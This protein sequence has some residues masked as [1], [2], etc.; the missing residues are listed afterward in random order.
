MGC[1]NR[2]Y[3]SVVFVVVLCLNWELHEQVCY[4][5][6]SNNSTVSQ[7]VES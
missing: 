3:N 5:I 6:V 1:Y 7:L 2:H 4:L